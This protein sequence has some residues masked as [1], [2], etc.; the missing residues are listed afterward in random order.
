[1]AEPQPRLEINPRVVVLG[2][3]VIR[4]AHV[5]SAGREA[6]YPLRPLGLLLLVLGFVAIGSEFGLKGIGA[7]AIRNSGSLPL[8]L[9][10]GA[11]G[12]GVFLLLFVRRLLVI[13]TAD[14]GRTIVPA[15]SDEM[16]STLVQRLREAM[17]FAAT[18]T[19]VGVSLPHAGHPPAIGVGEAGPGMRPASA[20]LGLPPGA[21]AGATRPP[22]ADPTGP[23]QTVPV[24]RRLE[25]YINGHAATGHAGQGHVGHAPPA[26]SVRTANG[27]GAPASDL[28]AAVEAAGQRR[29]PASALPH[30]PAGQIAT[31]FGH[32]HEPSA[33]QPQIR[34]ALSLPSTLPPFQP[35][36]DG[37]RDLLQLMEHVRRSDVQHKEALLDLLRVVE[38]HYRGRANREEAVA[39][40]RSF[41]DYV[42]QYLSDV[43][44]LIAYTERFGRHMLPR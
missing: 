5:V 23:P 25:P 21:V 8:W 35:R 13:R 15:G 32:P 6:T 16:S 34:E 22:L 19:A 20:P 38:D 27:I 17:E 18:Q 43:D 39:H 9:G 2:D 30:S 42:V 12:I 37:S 40:W 10:F 3:K 41:A 29:L 7:F 36:D 14:G 26:G 44:G 31:A 1:M 4:L 11:T 33:T 28:G 24:G